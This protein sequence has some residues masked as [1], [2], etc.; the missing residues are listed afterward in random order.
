MYS[1][2]YVVLLYW[3]LYY[4]YYV[5]HY[6][7]YITLQL[8]YNRCSMLYFEDLIYWIFQALKKSLTELHETLL[9]NNKPITQLRGGGWSA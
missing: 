2:V 8:H 5:L 3:V 6:E 4:F 7:R 1:V 9:E